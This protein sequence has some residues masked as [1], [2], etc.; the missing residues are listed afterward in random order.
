MASIP[1][2][3][4]FRDDK[5]DVRLIEEKDRLLLE[6]HDLASNRTWGPTPLVVLDVHEKPLR[7]ENRVEQYR[8]EAVNPLSCGAHVV[9]SDATRGVTAA[10][11]LM[12]ERGELVVRMTSTEIYEQLPV[13][14]RVFAVDV[15]PELLKV[16]GAA[17]RLLMP[18]NGATICRPHG[19]P[20]LRDAWMIY[21][22]QPRWE[23][24]SMFPIAA[25]WDGA[26]GGLM[27][28]ATESAPETQCRIATDGRGGG[29]I[30]LAFSLRRHWPDPVEPS[31]REIRIIPMP[32]KRRAIPWQRWRSGCG[33][34]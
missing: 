8:V 2:R 32:P 18:V 21:L 3:H 25:A 15:L 11:W 1:Y 13:H 7:R 14:H 34:I 22:E 33:V 5:L 6:L 23:L 16:E 17:A 4:Q 10:L 26:A 19:K 30:S 28:I 12:I 20:A 9:I 31:H 24:T 27:A 29:A